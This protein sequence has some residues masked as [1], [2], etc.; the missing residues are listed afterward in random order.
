VLGTA[1]VVL[2]MLLPLLDLVQ[3]IYMVVICLVVGG[4]ARAETAA[5][6]RLLLHSILPWRAVQQC[7]V[8]QAAFTS[9]RHLSGLPREHPEAYHCTQEQGPVVQP[10]TFQC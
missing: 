4:Q 1:A 2:V 7:T 5:M 10:A 3:A 6:F 8:L 9:L